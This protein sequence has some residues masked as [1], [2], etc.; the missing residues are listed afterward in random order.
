MLQEAL[1]KV[2][3]QMYNRLTLT[4]CYFVP[5]VVG[6]RPTL[7]L[8]RHFPLVSLQWCQNCW[9]TGPCYKGGHPECHQAL[10]WQ[11]AIRYSTE[12]AQLREGKGEKCRAWR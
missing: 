9:L 3:F 8:G 7:G 11:I 6:L 2:D 12:L 5:G 10:H 1:F 4:I